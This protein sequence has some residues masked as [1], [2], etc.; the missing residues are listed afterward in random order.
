MKQVK[1]VLVS[2][3]RGSEKTYE[4]VKEQLRE[5]YGD[6]VAEEYDP[7]TDCMPFSSWLAQGYAVRK[8]ARALKS[9]TI[10]E[11]K[12]DNDKVVKKICRTVN[13]FHKSQVQKIS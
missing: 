11:V 12:D 7:H 1:E 8:G 4:D 9:I 10:L 3:Y 5:R 2:P 13:L 6:D